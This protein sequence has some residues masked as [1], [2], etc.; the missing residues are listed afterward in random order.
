MDNISSGIGAGKTRRASRFIGRDGRSFLV[1]V[2]MQ[3]SAGRGPDLDAVE[4]IA[5]GGPDGVLVSW[6]IARRYPEAFAECGMI[7]RIDGALT[8]MGNHAPGDTFSLMYG[9]EEAVRIG[10]D[11]VALMAFPG[12]DDEVLSLQRLAAVVKECEAIGM[13]V[14]AESIPGTWSKTVPWDAEH[15]ARSARV[16][17]EIGADLVKTMA[18]PDLADL[19]AVVEQCEAPLLILGGPKRDSEEEAVRFAA[20]V[21]A[22]G[23]DGIVFGRNAWGAVDPT[24][25]VQRLHRAVHGE[26]K[27]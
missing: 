12:A 22:A 2:D 27:R 11:G 16:C 3:T 9:A 25:M 10:A 23:A 24:A 1:A 14:I 7:L 17:V 18:P 5:A 26:P 19:P 21:V 13:P 6:Q 4:P 20:D 8:E 15:I